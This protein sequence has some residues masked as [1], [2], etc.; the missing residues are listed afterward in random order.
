LR[1]ALLAR[2]ADTREGRKHPD[3]AGELALADPKKHF[4]LLLA[5]YQAD[6]GKDKPLPESAVA[7][8][9]AKRKETPPYDA[10]INDLDAALIDHVQVPESDLEALARERAHAIQGA[11]VNGQIDAARLFIVNSPPKPQSGDT[12]QVEL[13]LK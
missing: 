13:S 11:L 5:Q 2:V 7:V 10:A 3:T 4:D 6:F 8:Q 9:Q 12:V 1:S